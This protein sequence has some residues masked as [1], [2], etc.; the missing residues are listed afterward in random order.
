MK[1][2]ACHVET[3]FIELG[4]ISTVL[5]FSYF[6][7]IVPAISLIENTLVDLSFIKGRKN[8][9]RS[10]NTIKH[11]SN[12][13]KKSFMATQT[14]KY[15]SPA[16]MMTLVIDLAANQNLI[17]EITQ[18]KVHISNAMSGVA[19]DVDWSNISTMAKKLNVFSSLGRWN[20]TGTFTDETLA[21]Q[22]GVDVLNAFKNNVESN[23]RLIDDIIRSRTR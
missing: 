7:F 18:V 1:L 2:G 5:Y 15:S 17:L 20:I 9:I 13:F 10:L 8:S 6:V 19:T 14:R 16:D 4:Q 22:N 23:R 21:T 3:P 11:S 12:I